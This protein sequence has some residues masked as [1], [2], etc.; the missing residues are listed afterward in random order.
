[1]KGWPNI[2]VLVVASFL[3]TG[4]FAGIKYDTNELMYVN[5]VRTAAERID[6][7]S[8]HVARHVY[9]MDYKSQAF[10]NF[11]EFST[12][13]GLIAKY[14]KKL[15]GAE[16]YKVA[17]GLR[18]MVGEFAARYGPDKKPSVGYCESKVKNIIKT[19]TAI[20]KSM[21]GKIR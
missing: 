1:M 19:S 7:K 2:C 20:A 12:G 9:R 3:L 15:D 6:C 18:D 13:S 5:E 11:A 10:M 4:C 17:K 21:G 14:I 8:K 16:T